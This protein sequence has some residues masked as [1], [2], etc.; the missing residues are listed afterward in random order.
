MQNPY[1]PGQRGLEPIV[2][3]FDFGEVNQSLVC[4]SLEVGNYSAEP[5]K[6]V[7]VGKSCR[8]TE[9]D[10]PRDKIQPGQKATIQ[11]KWDTSGMRGSAKGDFTLF[12]SIGSKTD[13]YQCTVQFHAN[14]IPLFDVVPDTLEF[15]ED[16]AETKTVQLIPRDRTNT[17][18]IKS[19]ESNM[20]ALHTEKISDQMVDVTFMPEEWIDDRFVRPKIILRTNCFQEEIFVIPIQVKVHND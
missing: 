15:I 20:T 16:K 13:M 2:S 5:V 9:V 10:L 7:A 4:G 14:V 1:S 8:C 19:V 6:I 17:I 18:F 12:Y 11:C 3:V